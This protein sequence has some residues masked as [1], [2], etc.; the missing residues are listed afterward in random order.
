V[1]GARDR[2]FYGAMAIA[3]GLT[4]LCGF[5]PTYYSRI[6]AGGPEATFGGRPFTSAVHWHAA[7]FTAWVVLFFVQTA[8][9]ASRRVAWHRRLGV[10]TA[11]LAAAMVVAGVRVAIESAAHGS[12]PPGV[13]PLS[14]L[15]IP[16]F[17]MLL[18]S[19]FV[20]AAI[21]R[22]GDREAHKRLMILAY[23]NLLA[24]AFARLPGVLPLGPLAFYGGAL[25][26]VVAGVIYDIV[27]RR[28]VHRVYLWGGAIFALSVPVRLF[29]S[30]TPAWLAFAKS[31]TG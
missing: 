25:L 13:P 26:F 11:V 20:A 2:L 21:A 17:D 8:L 5:G 23:V 4:V 12:A 7:L 6:F 30:G 15:A 31:L 14:F 22:R 3:M 19:G 27:S 10:L 18:F 24:A 29:I 28:R 16:L 9:I 1:I